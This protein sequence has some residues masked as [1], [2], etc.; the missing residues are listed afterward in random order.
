MARVG[1][2][3]QRPIRKKSVT[4]TYTTE[5]ISRQLAGACV[6]LNKR[7]KVIEHKEQI[8]WTKARNRS[9]G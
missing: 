6:K 7:T 8:C 1:I 3:V 2:S 5:Q 9:I 4:K